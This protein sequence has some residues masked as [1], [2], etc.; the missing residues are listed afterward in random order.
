MMRDFAAGLTS[1]PP[2]RIGWLRRDRLV[3]IRDSGF[4]RDAMGKKIR[5]RMPSVAYLVARSYP[6]R[7]IGRDNQLP[8]H[9]GTDLRNFKRLTLNH[10]VIMGRKTYESIGRPLPRRVNIVLSRTEIEERPNLFWARDPETATYL[11]DLHSIYLMQKQFFVIGGEHIF[12]IYRHLVSKVWL[13]EVYGG[14]INGDAKFEDDFHRREWR[15]F[16]EDDHPASEKDEYP[17]RISVLLRWK[18]IHRERLREEFVRRN[19][20]I[21]EWLEDYSELLRQ[22]SERETLEQSEEQL[23]LLF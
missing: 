11:A 5:V 8:W 10:A 14:R 21:E 17:F 4:R 15:Y 3:I 1:R 18:S 7:F 20:D 16:R 12:S 2:S 9:L 6:D 22:E 19:P 23:N 13:T